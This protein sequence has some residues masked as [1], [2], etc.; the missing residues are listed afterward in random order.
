MHVP[1]SNAGRELHQ[2]VSG[3]DRALDRAR[4]YQRPPHPRRALEEARVR[5]WREEAM[6]HEEVDQDLQAWG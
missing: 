4:E 2:G 1:S 5:F 6:P 3:L